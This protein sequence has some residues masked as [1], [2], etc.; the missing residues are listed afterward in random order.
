M[1]E[2]S[3]TPNQSVATQTTGPIA[4]PNSKKKE[5]HKV[6]Q[7][8]LKL[9]MSRTSLGPRSMAR[10][11]KASLELIPSAAKIKKQGQLVVTS[12]KESD[13]KDKDREPLPDHE[14]I[15]IPLTPGN[16]DAEAFLYQLAFDRFTGGNPGSEQFIKKSGN[17]YQARNN[18]YTS[19]GI[20]VPE[21]RHRPELTKDQQ[22]LYNAAVRKFGFSYWQIQLSYSRPDRKAVRSKVYKNLKRPNLQGVLRK[23]T[24]AKESLDS[25]IDVDSKS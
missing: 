5:Q 8:T 23:I 10:S 11:I 9:V 2:N 24:E 7:P 17:F 15:E 25:K 13:D 12:A 14:V 3:V 20:P 21:G 18:W 4:A 6:T 22:E 16:E 1:N 19:M